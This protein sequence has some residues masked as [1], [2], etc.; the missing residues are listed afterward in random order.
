MEAAQIP[1]R[2][3]GLSATL[4]NYVDVANFLWVNP[5]TGLFFFDSRFRPVPL[6]MTFIGMCTPI[7]YSVLLSLL[8]T[9]VVDLFFFKVKL[10]I[11]DWCEDCCWPVFM[12]CVTISNP[13]SFFISETGVNPEIRSWRKHLSEWARCKKVIGGICFTTSEELRLYNSV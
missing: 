6:G 10:T 7:F 9:Q 11:D 12:T 4:P 8:V 1:I 3:V 2:I 5:E 13:D